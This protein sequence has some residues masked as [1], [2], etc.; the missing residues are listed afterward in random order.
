VQELEQGAAVRCRPHEDQ[1]GPWQ[2]DLSEGGGV[3]RLPF[4]GPA[5][6]AREG[7][8]VQ[9]DESLVAAESVGQVRRLAGAL[10]QRAGELA[11]AHGDPAAGAEEVDR[12]VE[13][14][15]G[16]GSLRVEGVP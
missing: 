11:H 6:D 1:A 10:A 14:R 15:V 5:V 3:G 16:H 8:V 13:R 4:G 2:V 9:D 7:A 12:A